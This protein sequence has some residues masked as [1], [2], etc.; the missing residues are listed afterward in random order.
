MKMI[1]KAIDVKE[2]DERLMFEL[3][4][5]KEMATK[6]NTNACAANVTASAC[7]ANATM[8]NCTGQK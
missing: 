4:G 7:G 2:I 6:V 5:R 3:E 1:N 8:S